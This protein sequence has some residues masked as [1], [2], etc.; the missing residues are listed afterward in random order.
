[1]PGLGQVTHPCSPGTVYSHSQCA[2]VFYTPSLG[3]QADELMPANDSGHGHC[4]IPIHL[5]IC[6]AL[7]ARIII[8]EALYIYNKVSL[9]LISIMH[10]AL[11]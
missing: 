10:L 3:K 5:L 8:V 7:R 9:S 2:C 1:M 4:S 11:M 6:A